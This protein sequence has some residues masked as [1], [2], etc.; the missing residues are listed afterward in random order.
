MANSEIAMTAPIIADPAG[1]I[2]GTHIAMTAPILQE[3]SKGSWR[4]AYV[5]PAD[6]TLETAP[7]P[8]D[9][10]LELAEVAGKKVAVIQFSGLWSEESIQDET[11]E[12]NDWIS[13]NN[14]T[15]SSGPRWA[16]Y[17]PPWT[18]PFLR[19][20]EVMIDVQQGK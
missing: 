11:S 10:D 12:L 4:Y 14:L 8:L 9:D 16:C 6:L 13:V 20:N 15:S 5:L 7:K 1:T 2:P 19:R 18:I 17:N 3:Y